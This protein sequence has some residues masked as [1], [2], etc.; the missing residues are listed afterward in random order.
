MRDGWRDVPG[1]SPGTMT[2]HF[3]KGE[4]DGEIRQWKEKG[5]FSVLLV[6][7]CGFI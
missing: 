4:N 1:T 5:N 2:L 7:C 6:S 3:G